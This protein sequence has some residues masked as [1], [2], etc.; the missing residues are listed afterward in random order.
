MT[1]ARLLLRSFPRVW[2]DRYADE[3]DDLIVEMD[4]GKGTRVRVAVDL[5]R[6]GIAER[7]GASGLRG[8]RLPAPERARARLLLVLAAWS[9][10]V[11][12]GVSLQKSSEH[13]QAA[14][15][16]ARRGVPADAFAILEIVAVLASALVLAGIAAALP[17]LLAR[18]RAG[19]TA[20]LGRPLLRALT[21]TLVTLAAALPLVLWAHSLSTAQRN[22]H[23]TPYA[24]AV[25]GTALLAIVSLAA[26]TAAALAAATRTPLGGRLLRLELALGGAVT[27][28]MATMSAAA[29]VWWVALASAAPAF[30][31]AGGWSIALAPRALLPTL[32]M[33]AATALGSIG[34]AGAFRAASGGRL[35]GAHDA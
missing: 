17:S 3:L 35:H 1:A 22:G 4:K 19:E 16:A 27:A 7:L 29:I 12:A 24:L 14:T 9:L 23:D 15:P 11:V 18:I 33:L 26:W 25:A 28:A 30:T 6:A 13:W 21:S 2:R 8:D 20:G 31:G 34:T 10:F 32:A 5:V